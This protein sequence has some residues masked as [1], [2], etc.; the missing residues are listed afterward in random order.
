MK[1]VMR[2]AG[3]RSLIEAIRRE[4]GYAGPIVHRPLQTLRYKGSFASF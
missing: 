2:H 4:A 3:P 1:R